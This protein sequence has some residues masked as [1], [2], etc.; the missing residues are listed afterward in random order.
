MREQSA[1]SLL[2]KY[3]KFPINFGP[4]L[5]ISSSSVNPRVDR[6]YSILNIEISVPSQFLPRLSISTVSVNPVRF[7]A[8]SIYRYI[9]Y[10]AYFLILLVIMKSLLHFWNFFNISGLCGQLCLQSFALNFWCTLN[11]IEPVNGGSQDDF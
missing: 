1:I 9:V 8:Y 4:R 2:F 10:T 11:L 6:V 5:S 7:Q 3:G